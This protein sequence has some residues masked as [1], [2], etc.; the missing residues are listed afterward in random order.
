M[1]TH[2]SIHTYN[3]ISSSP[4][5]FLCSQCYLIFQ[6]ISLSIFLCKLCHSMQLIKFR[7]SKHA[8]STSC[9]ISMEGTLSPFLPASSISSTLLVPKPCHFLFDHHVAS[10][11]FNQGASCLLYTSPSPRD[12]TLSR[13]PSSA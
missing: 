6:H 9:K 1:F 2:S 5:I 8:K 10:H 11:V 3:P 12:A 13:M 4:L 7:L